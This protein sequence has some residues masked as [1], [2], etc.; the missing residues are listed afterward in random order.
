MPLPLLP[1]RIAPVLAERATQYPIV[2]VTGPRQSGKTTLCRQLFPDKPWI[3]LEIPDVRREAIEDPRGFLARLP[4]GAILDEVQRTPDLP[5]YL[6]WD[7]D[8]RPDARGRW[9]LT[10][11]NNLQLHR[12]V[13][14]SLA[15]R[16]ALLNVLPLGLDELP[17]DQWR[18]QP[19]TTVAFRGGYPAPLHRDIPVSVWLGD[20]FATYVERDVRD[21]L[22]VN[23]LLAFEKFVRLCAGRVGQL[24]NTSALGADAGL[25]HPTAKAWLSVLE[26]SY[27]V[28]QLP[29]WS[30]NLTAREVKSPKLYFWDTGLLCWL[31]G[32]RRPEELDLHP[33]RGPIFEN[34]IIAQLLKAEIHRGERPPWWFYRDARGLE[35]DAVR[36]APA[37][38][39]GLA[40]E[41]K[42]GQTLASDMA[43]SLKRLA[44][45]TS[46]QTP[47]VRLDSAVIY[48]G[49]AEGGVGGLPAL[50]WQALA[51]GPLATPLRTP[52]TP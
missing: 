40:L 35:V 52:R 5:S 22:R 20:Y 8:T 21:V 43:D 29:P 19:W 42:S 48:G 3:L 14:Q 4:E 24:L 6:Q 41:I 47:P 37:A 28:F 18:D 49:V 23:D 26:A 15:G 51:Q 34:M 46:Q 39:T 32:L 31:L 50:S 33:L 9:I 38:A 30:A 36:I 1:R 13:S 16:T 10:G 45:R 11:S 17:S 25:S 44:E 2:T 12:A 7:A 27:L